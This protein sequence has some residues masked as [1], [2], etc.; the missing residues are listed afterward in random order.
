MSEI[1]LKINN[2]GY[3][4]SCDEGQEQRLADLGS[5]VNSR[6]NDIAAAGAATNES[7]LLVLTALVLA[8]EI[9]EMRDEMQDLRHRINYF[10]QNP[11]MAASSFAEEE[12]IIAQAI[13]H[14]AD[15]IEGIA[16]RLQLPPTE[17]AA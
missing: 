13:E 2:R 8:D 17:R 5:Y 14:L 6:L 4:L 16:D 1:T 12:A 3:S 10:R 9:F 15:K 11:N 7:H